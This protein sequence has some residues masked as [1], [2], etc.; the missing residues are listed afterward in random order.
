LSS[1]IIE[2]FFL[3]KNHLLYLKVAADAKDKLFI[4]TP[5]SVQAMNN[6][7]YDKLHP[8]KRRKRD[9]FAL[10]IG[11][12]SLGFLAPFFVAYRE[13]EVVRINFLY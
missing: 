10:F 11:V 1:S 7:W 4:A 9:L 12:I 2:I 3:I 13:G 5:C 8:D 6:I